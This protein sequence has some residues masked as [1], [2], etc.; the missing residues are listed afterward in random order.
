MDRYPPIRSTCGR[1]GPG[2]HRRA[3]APDR[4]GPPK[5]ACR[6]MSP[7]TQCKPRQRR[8]CGGRDWRCAGGDVALEGLLSVRANDE[9]SGPLGVRTEGTRRAGRGP[10]RRRPVAQERAT[11]RRGPKVRGSVLAPV[12]R[13]VT[14][15]HRRPAPAAAASHSELPW[16]AGTFSPPRG[17]A[18]SRPLSPLESGAALWRRP[19]PTAAAVTGS[20]PAGWHQS[21]DGPRPSGSSA[22]ALVVVQRRNAAPLT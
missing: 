8:R 15:R 14:A 1:D 16:R 13:A 21:E 5:A 10:S 12:A 7:P 20:P 18:I 4:P 9:C 3:P 2:S 6:R 22:A 17:A 11:K 19:C